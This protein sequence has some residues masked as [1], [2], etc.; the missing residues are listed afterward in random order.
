MKSMGYNNIR[1][2][3]KSAEHICTIVLSDE[4]R[5]EL[6]PERIAQGQAENSFCYPYSDVIGRI[7]TVLSPLGFGAKAVALLYRKSGAN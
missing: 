5:A 1:N 7:R 4:A 6:L 2:R 3:A